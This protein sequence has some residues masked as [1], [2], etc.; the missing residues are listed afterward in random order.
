M[1][2]K[3]IPSSDCPIEALQNHNQT[4]KSTLK[5]Q[6]QHP[7]TALISQGLAA[8]AAHGSDDAA[9]KSHWTWH[10]KSLKH[11]TLKIGQ[12]STFLWATTKF[13]VNAFEQK[14]HIWVC[15]LH[16]VQQNRCKSHIALAQAFAQG[17]SSI[18]AQ[19]QF[20]RTTLLQKP[21]AHR[22]KKVLW[23]LN[24]AGVYKYTST[25]I[26]HLIPGDWY[27]IPVI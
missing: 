2:K 23:E 27:P 6:P 4:S 25:T 17:N 10:W 22:C 1:V 18:N 9:R 3:S 21:A 7:V 8:A 5:S 16:I 24:N 14:S 19:W 26:Q 15:P 12:K 13:N 11:W 20:C